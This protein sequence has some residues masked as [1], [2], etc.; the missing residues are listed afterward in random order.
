MDATTPVGLLQVLPFLLYIWSS[1]ML[2]WGLVATALIYK[3]RKKISTLRSSS[4]R[5]SDKYTLGLVAIVNMLLLWYLV[6]FNATQDCITW[7][8]VV[9]VFYTAHLTCTSIDIVRWWNSL[10]LYT[11]S[12][13]IYD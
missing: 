7:I 11:T 3:L 1:I 9:N 8:V 6:S 12:Q 5:K 13:Q 2:A 4:T 10:K